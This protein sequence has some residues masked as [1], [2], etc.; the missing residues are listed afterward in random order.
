[1]LEV[2]S[3]VD[4]LW[5]ERTDKPLVNIGGTPFVAGIAAL[6]QKTRP[7]VMIGVDLNHSPWLNEADIRSR[8]IAFIFDH[9]EGVPALCGSAA[10]KSTIT[11]K[12]PLMPQ[13][14]AI[15]CPPL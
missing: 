2:S 14:T 6:G 13:L 10:F 5:K 1:M 12:D 11:L 15:I 3:A 9:D 7:N 4:R 8:G